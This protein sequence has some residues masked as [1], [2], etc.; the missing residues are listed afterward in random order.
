MVCSARSRSRRAISMGSPLSTIRDA[1]SNISYCALRISASMI[2]MAMSFFRSRPATRYQTDVARSWGSI[3]LRRC[4]TSRCEWSLGG[5]CHPL[6]GF[7]ESALS[8]EQRGFGLSDHHLGFVAEL[9]ALFHEALRR[10]PQLLR[11]EPKCRGHRRAAQEMSADGVG[12]VQTTLRAEVRA[13][14]AQGVC[15]KSHVV[16]AD[17]TARA[18]GDD[19][20]PAESDDQR[21]LHRRQAVRSFAV[22]M[23][24]KAAIRVDDVGNRN[25]TG[26]LR[27]RYLHVAPRSSMGRFPGRRFLPT[28]VRSQI[29]LG[30]PTFVCGR[31]TGR[32][33]A[34]HT[35]NG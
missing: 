13:A 1:S 30:E 34:D 25:W 14:P 18:S 6:Q 23:R 21:P 10:I 32:G 26:A 17:V 20:V 19:V 7:T 29:P 9:V 16:E 2:S 35:T 31:S 24:Q 28:G 4:T 5:C 11:P 3:G 12:E 33:T 27:A 22:P 15:G 8:P